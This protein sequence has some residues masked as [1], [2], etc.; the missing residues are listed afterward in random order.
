MLRGQLSGEYVAGLFLTR[1]FQ[2]LRSPQDTVV[3]C[4]ATHRS[5]REGIAR[6]QCD[7]R[8]VTLMVS[9]RTLSGQG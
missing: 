7:L 9:H 6:D 2:R 3:D 8:P 4:Y 1:F 5:R